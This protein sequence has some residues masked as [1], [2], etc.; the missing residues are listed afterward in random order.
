V[1]QA[2]LIGHHPAQVAEL[3]LAGG[4]DGLF[5]PDSGRSLSLGSGTF[6][7]A[8]GSLPQLASPIDLYMTDGVDQPTGEISVLDIRFEIELQTGRCS[9]AN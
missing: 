9:R 5:R 3:A 8:E 7:G 4:V 6:G 1:W 2:G